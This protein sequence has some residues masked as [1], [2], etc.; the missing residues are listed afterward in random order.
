M[1]VCDE[2]RPKHGNGR[3]Y[4]A[5]FSV[6][7]WA[8]RGLKRPTLA[9]P[10]SLA[11]SGRIAPQERSSASDAGGQAST[12]TIVISC[13]SPAQMGHIEEA[14]AEMRTLL[15]LQ[16]N[17]SAALRIADVAD[18]HA[19]TSVAPSG[20]L[21][22][23]RAAGVTRR[24]N[25]GLPNKGADR[26]AGTG[27][28]RKSGRFQG[29]GR[30]FL[31]V[32]NAATELSCFG[33]RASALATPPAN[34]PWTKGTPM[35][36][37]L[38]T[39]ATLASLATLPM[40]AAAERSG[41]AGRRTVEFVSVTVTEV[42]SG[43]VTKPY[44]ETPK[45]NLLY[46]KGGRLMFVTFKDERARPAGAGVTDAEAVALFRTL[47]AGSGTYR[48]EGKVMFSTFETSWSQIDRHHPEEERGD[49]RQQADSDL[50]SGEGHRHRPR[51]HVH[52]CPGED[53]IGL[54]SGLAPGRRRPLRIRK[55]KLISGAT[56]RLIRIEQ[57]TR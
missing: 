2:R 25:L 29:A 43:K 20:R 49:R 28:C 26:D 50:R 6:S 51:H 3:R 40:P 4:R 45:G 14:R 10:Y 18:V 37:T 46:T 31:K 57:S 22:Q 44:G 12:L 1:C 35:T 17:M 42:A 54:R 38:L 9:A 5:K 21:A 7:P 19:R 23:S 33:D 13:A 48:I 36:R 24:P 56:N 11:P 53:R 8:T 30:E 39:A 15:Q 52:E 34:A 41:I 32:S 47:A 16:P 55:S 27:R